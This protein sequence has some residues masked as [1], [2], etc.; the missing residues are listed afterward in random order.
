M[1]ATEND[2]L[3]PMILLRAR[4]IGTLCAC[5]FH[6]CAAPRDRELEDYVRADVTLELGAAFHDPHIAESAK[7]LRVLWPPQE[8]LCVCW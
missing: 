1:L 8:E 7:I 2:D 5:A 4:L 6:G 3:Y